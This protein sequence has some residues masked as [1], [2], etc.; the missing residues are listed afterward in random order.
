MCG[1]VGY[2]GKKEAAPILLKGLKRLEYRGYDSAGI[3]VMN[4]K[5]IDLVKE[6]GKTLDFQ[7][8]AAVEHNMKSRLLKGL[9]VKPED[10][11][12]DSRKVI[13]FNNDVHVGLAAPKN[14]MTSYFYKNADA[15]ELLF[16]HKWSGT[17]K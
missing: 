9:E 6:V 16:V 3:A 12:L 5:G 4:G 2:L 13:L 8:R 17:I 11:Y 15:D 7:P 14:S 1:I 10:D